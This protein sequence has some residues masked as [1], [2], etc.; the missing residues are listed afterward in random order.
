MCIKWQLINNW[1]NGAVLNPGGIDGIIKYLVQLFVYLI[2]KNQYPN[3]H[4]L[5]QFQDGPVYLN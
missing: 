3:T 2:E 5:K 1:I 4:Y